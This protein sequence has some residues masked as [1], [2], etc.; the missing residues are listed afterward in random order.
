MQLK[1]E[2]WWKV[3]HQSELETEDTS[4][5]ALKFFWSKNWAYVKNL[6]NSVI[7]NESSSRPF[8]ETII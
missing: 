6:D 1:F 5:D 3:F 7:I 8:K 2:I 4:E